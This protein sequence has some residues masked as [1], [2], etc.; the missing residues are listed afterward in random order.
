L[1][2]HRGITIHGRSEF[3]ESDSFVDESLGGQQRGVLV[4]AV[5]QSSK[6]V[7]RLRLLGNR[8]EV[9]IDVT[10]GGPEHGHLLDEGL[11][12]ARSGRIDRR[13]ATRRS[14]ESIRLVF[15]HLL[16]PDPHEPL[17]FPRRQICKRRVLPPHLPVDLISFLG[18]ASTLSLKTS[19]KLLD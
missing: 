6:L 3:Q 18:D 17:Q 12:R 19:P 11:Q 14:I 15:H 16:A 2:L 13:A 1:S 10:G 8:F 9:G 4:I 5:V 7:R